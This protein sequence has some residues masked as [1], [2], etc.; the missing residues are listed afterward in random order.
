LTQV[1]IADFDEDT[2][3]SRLDATNTP[4]IGLAISGGGTQS[5]IGGLGIWQAFDARH[6]PAVKAKTGGLSQCLTYI[7]GLSGGGAVTVSTL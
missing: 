4:V 2:F 3:L 5:G 7:T 1:S 6:L